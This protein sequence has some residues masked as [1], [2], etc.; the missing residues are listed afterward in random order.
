VQLPGIELQFLTYN[1]R[2]LTEAGSLSRYSYQATLST[3]EG[4]WF[5]SW[6]GQDSFLLSL[7]FRP[8]LGPTKPRM[9]P[10]LEANH[11]H[12]SSAEV[13]YGGAVP[14]LPPYVLMVW[15]LIS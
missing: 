10:G 3:S 12:P 2:W 6:Q 1:G 11:S 4:S 14:P 8:A 9:R 5:D 13:K 7:P 15:C